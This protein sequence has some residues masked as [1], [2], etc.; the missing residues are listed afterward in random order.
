M[1]ETEILIPAS[2]SPVTEAATALGA[3]SAG[4]EPSMHPAEAERRSV[5]APALS[6]LYPSAAARLSACCHGGAKMAVLAYSLGKREINQY[7]SVKNAKLV[8]LVAVI[9]LTVFHTVSRYYGGGDTCD[10]LLSSG[11]FLGEGVWQPNGC[12]MHRY[13]SVEAKNCL[14]QKR[15]AFV[16]DS[17]IRQLFYSYIKIINPD[18]REDGNKHENIPFE[19]R[20]SSLNVDFLWYAEVND[21]MKER[22]VAWTE[23][24]TVKPDV[25]ILGAATWSIKLHGGSAESLLQYKSNLTAIVR[26]LE[27]L[28]EDSDV[29]W[30]LQDPVNEDMLSDNR[31]MITNQQ[32]DLYNDAAV[33]TLNGSKRNGR[34]QVKILG[35]SRHAAA[36]TIGE[37]V[38]GLHLPESTRNVGAMVLMN[39]VCNKV[40]KPIDGS[41]CSPLPP[42]NVLQKLTALVF[43]AA[44]VA[45]AALY[46]LG[47]NRHRKSKLASD[48]ESGE[49]KKPRPGRRA[50]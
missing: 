44:M 1:E 39:S 31:K 9:L 38:D 47:Y 26:F 24:T 19:D 6:L 22:L 30:V 37:S 21:S 33:S 16:G 13:K 40:L 23:D 8:S 17:R 34:A 32:I 36:E 5:S 10:W 11:R 29:Y 28:A 49:E 12:M 25:I 2:G 27:K 45:F 4:G 3:A 7:F 42:T 50:A 43:L 20:S 18:V 14:V 35:A 48:V 46:V 41:C 15:V